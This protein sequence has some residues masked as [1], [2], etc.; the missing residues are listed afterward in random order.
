[1]PIVNFTARWVESIKAPASGQ[2]DYWDKKLRR[3]SLRVTARG[4]KTW[5]I[6]YRFHGRKRRLSLGTF[7]PVELADARKRARTMLSLVDSGQ[8]PAAEKIRTLQAKTF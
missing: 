1:M 5:N 7:P 3:F 2:I 8:D 4:R 6:Y